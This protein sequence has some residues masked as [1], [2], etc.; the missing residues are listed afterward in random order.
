MIEVLSPSRIGFAEKIRGVLGPKI[1]TP[2]LEV[3]LHQVTGRLGLQGVFLALKHGV[4]PTLFL[5]DPFSEKPQSH[6]LIDGQRGHGV[7]LATRFSYAT[8]GN[9]QWR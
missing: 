6:T 2:L 5:A 1:Y 9:V 4:G 3:A 8:D 7:A